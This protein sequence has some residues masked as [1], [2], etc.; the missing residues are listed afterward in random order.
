MDLVPMEHTPIYFAA[1]GHLG[2]NGIL[3]LLRRTV[4]AG[5]TEGPGRVYEEDDMQ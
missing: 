3:L 5:T 1:T 4:W 2:M